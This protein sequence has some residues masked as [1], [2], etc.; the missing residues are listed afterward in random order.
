MGRGDYDDSS[1]IPFCIAWVTAST[2]PFTSSFWKILATWVLTVLSL[3]E[4]EEAISLL[5]EVDPE[6]GQ[7][8]KRESR[9]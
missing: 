1:M 8:A 4:R 3:I 5:A 7:V 6:F 2:R 9:S